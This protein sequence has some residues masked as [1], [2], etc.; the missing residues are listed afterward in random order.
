MAFT[1]MK[2]KW[3]QTLKSPN[4]VVRDNHMWPPWDQEIWYYRKNS[5]FYP[6]FTHKYTV[7]QEAHS[8]A[9]CEV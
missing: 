7:T 3:Q 6:Q 1:G 4:S 5:I 9:S 8:L 2:F